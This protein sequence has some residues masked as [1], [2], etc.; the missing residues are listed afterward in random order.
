MAIISLG[1]ATVAAFAGRTG[2]AVSMLVLSGIDAFVSFS[3]HQFIRQ[4]GRVTEL[5]MN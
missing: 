4:G 2:G 5:L 3:V 1:G